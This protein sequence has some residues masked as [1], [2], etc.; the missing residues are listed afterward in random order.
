MANNKYIRFDWAAKTVLRDKANFCI[1]EGLVTVLLGETVTI[2]E[3]LPKRYLHKHIDDNL[4]QITVKVINR[5][6]EVFIIEINQIRGLHYI[7]RI[8]FG[9]S[10]IT[11]N[12]HRAKMLLS[13]LEWLDFYMLFL[14]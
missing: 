5:R 6:N 3:T 2:I 7:E 13:F 9:Q 8:M 1:L 14:E 10:A 11:E 12:V 4:F